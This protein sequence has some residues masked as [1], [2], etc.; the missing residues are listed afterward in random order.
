LFSRSII[1]ILKN[2]IVSEQNIRASAYSVLQCVG[3]MCAVGR[4]V[5]DGFNRFRRGWKGRKICG[6][7]RE[8]V[9]HLKLTAIKGKKEREERKRKRDRDRDREGQ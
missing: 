3:G 2:K 1:I 6:D 5:G 9:A 4:S 7:G 8:E